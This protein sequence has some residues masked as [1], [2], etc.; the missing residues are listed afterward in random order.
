MVELCPGVRLIE[1]LQ[2]SNLNSHWANLSTFDSKCKEEGDE[3]C[4]EWKGVL[5]G[6]R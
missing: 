6:L 1:L 3:I 5:K 4:G 2:F